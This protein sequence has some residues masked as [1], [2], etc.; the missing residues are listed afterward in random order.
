MFTPLT[1]VVA[2]G[3][4]LVAL[5]GFGLAIIGRSPTRPFVLA[6]VIAEAE[7]IIHACVAGV[8]M[9]VDHRPDRMGEYLGYLFTSVVLLPF[10]LQLTRAGATRWDSA[11]IGAVALAVGVA[12]IRLLGLW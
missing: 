7:V 11:T 4:F 6:A 1:F 3:L 12:V 9:T 8:A 2:A 5:W 10:V